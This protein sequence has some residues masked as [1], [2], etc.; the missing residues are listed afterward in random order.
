MQAQN[1]KRRYKERYYGLVG[2]SVIIWE[3]RNP[4]SPI[5]PFDIK[6]VRVIS[7]HKNF[8][9]A[10]DEGNSRPYVI[11]I[12][13]HD[14]HTDRVRIKGFEEWKHPVWDKGRTYAEYERG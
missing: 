5:Y 8:I 3:G 13:K 11:S 6:K 10:I 2:E 4:A 1:G 9:R 12:Q 7:E 14:I